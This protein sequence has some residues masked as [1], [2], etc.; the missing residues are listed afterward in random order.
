M[1][2]TG[3]EDLK[4]IIAE[5]GPFDWASTVEGDHDQ[6]QAWPMI[7]DMGHALCNFEMTG[8]LLQIPEV[9][10]SQYWNTRWIWNDSVKYSV[11]DALDM[12]GNFNATGLSMMIWGNYLADKM[13]KAS[14]TVQLRT[15]ASYTAEE[16]QLFVYFLNLSDSAQNVE[17]EIHHPGEPEVIFAGELAGNG[18]DDLDPAWREVDK[19]D[20]PT[21]VRVSG[22]SVK[23]IEFKMN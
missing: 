16:E 8:K 4:I 2:K 6:S 14:G 23:V 1:R 19:P 18:A 22:T 11:Y 13:V 12:D 15:F 9:A 3:Q 10:F 21:S 5:Y 7:N 17:L 20:I